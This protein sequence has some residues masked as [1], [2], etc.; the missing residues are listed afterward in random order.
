M[1]SDRSIHGPEFPEG[2]FKPTERADPQFPPYK[3]LG[4]SKRAFRL[5]M[6]IL[7]GI[8]L[9]PMLYSLLK[10]AFSRF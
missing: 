2:Y 4:L 1:T 3:P 9:G 5:L 6:L 10:G 8:V 7:W